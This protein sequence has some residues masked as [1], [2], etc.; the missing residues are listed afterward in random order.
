[1]KKYFVLLCCVCLLFSG[2]RNE[3]EEA[4]VPTSIEGTAA[5]QPTPSQTEQPEEE[6]FIHRKKRR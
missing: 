2:C 4:A 1:M 3:A 5:P 6:F